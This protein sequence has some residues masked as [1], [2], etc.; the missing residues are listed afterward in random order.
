MPPNE[1]SK[2]PRKGAEGPLS[3]KNKL[4]A[5]LAF[6]FVFLNCTRVLILGFELVFFVSLLKLAV[7]SSL[8]KGHAYCN[9]NSVLVLMKSSFQ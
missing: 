1:H 9:I 8:Y 5:C 2:T 6:C 3:D 4:E 7:D